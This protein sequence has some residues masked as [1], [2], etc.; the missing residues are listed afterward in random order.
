VKLG[1]SA[2][3]P[4]EPFALTS[5]PLAVLLGV[6]RSVGDR[7]HEGL[8]LLDAQDRL[9]YA[10]PAAL[11]LLGVQRESQ[12]CGREISALF[13]R[14]DDEVE[15][16]RHNILDESGVAAAQLGVVVSSGSRRAAGPVRMASTAAVVGG[17]FAIRDVAD[18]GLDGDGLGCVVVRVI[19][20][21]PEAAVD[22]VVRDLCHL[23]S[24][25]TRPEDM[26][27]RIGSD[28][29]ALFAYARTLAGVKSIAERLTARGRREIHEEFRVGIALG[30]GGDTAS[31]LVRTAQVDDYTAKPRMRG[32]VAMHRSGAA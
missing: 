6:L 20:D 5:V 30:G 21:A 28:T 4:V 26:V 2:F 27:A 14:I 15:D 22:S 7:L 16:R 9:Q 13:R 18:L 24:R 17:P 23:I 25:V 19:S 1:R 32:R 31:T 11:R 12:V 3:R 10:N 29:V 8:Y